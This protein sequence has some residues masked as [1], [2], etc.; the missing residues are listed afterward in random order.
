MKAEHFKR[1]IDALGR[2]NTLGT[3]QKTLL[4]FWQANLRFKWLFLGTCS[5]WLVGM[6]LQKL[7]MALVAARALD[8]L[9]VLY[10]SGATDYWPALLPYL[11]AFAAVGIVGQVFIDGGLLLLSKLET[12]VRPAMQQKIFDRLTRHSLTFHANTFSGALVTQVNRFTN[13]YIVITDNFVIAV[14]KMA[15]NVFIAIAIIAFFSPLIALAMFV[16][17]VLF[18]WLNVVLTKGRIHLSKRASAADSVLTAHLA[19]TLGNISAVKAFAREQTEATTHHNKATDRAQKRYKAWMRAIQNDTVLGALM[20]ILQLGVLT[21]SIMGVMNNAITIGT[22][23]LIQVYIAQLMSE[24]WGLSNLSRTWEQNLSDAEEMTQILEEDIEVPDPAKPEKVRINKGAIRFD[25]VAFTHADS[26]EEDVLF[27]DFTLSIKPGEKIGLV[28]QSGSGKTTLTKLLLRFADIDSGTIRIDGQDITHIRQ[29]D[30]RTSIAYVPQEPALFHRSLSENIAYGKPDATTE[31]IQ[32][33]ARKAHADGFIE[34]LPH[35]Y[36]TMVGERGVKLS[37]G[38]RQ[39][40][41]IARAILKDAPIL[42]LDEATSALDS[43]SEKLIQAALKQFMK[44]RTTLVIAHR[45]STIQSMDRIVVLQ[46]GRIVEQ[47]SHHEL[48]AR[49]GAYAGLWQHQSGGFLEEK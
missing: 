48:L 49:Q 18:V 1:R 21:L 46:E 19:D 3:T 12:R 47:G 6:V 27:E 10:T 14:L 28:G 37:G 17:T 36:D 44:G 7:L 31:E 38:Q 29:Q 42:V 26:K 11:I 20:I 45:L 25:R 43:E 30:L 39:R 40:I 4:L 35:G 24:L 22:L 15:T 13:A 41:A 23:L 33:A 5:S 8:K 16:W 9:I 32:E 2:T 34:K